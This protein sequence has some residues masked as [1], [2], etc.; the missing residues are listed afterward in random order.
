M[1]NH[2]LMRKIIEQCQYEVVEK[3][4]YLHTSKEVVKKKNKIDLDKFKTAYL[5]TNVN[6]G[7]RHDLEWTRMKKEE[8]KLKEEIEKKQFK[9]ATKKK[10]GSQG[11]TQEEIQELNKKKEIEEKEFRKRHLERAFAGIDRK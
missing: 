10:N 4:I 9:K 6:E 2:Q 7:I 11:L 8:R 5:S 1:Q 3:E